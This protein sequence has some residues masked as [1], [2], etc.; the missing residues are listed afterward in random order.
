MKQD[1]AQKFGI[2]QREKQPVADM[3]RIGKDPNF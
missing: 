1:N 2:F 3:G